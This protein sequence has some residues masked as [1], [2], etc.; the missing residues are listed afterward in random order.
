[1]KINLRYIFTV[2]ISLVDDI[3]I[4]VLAV[5]IMSLFGIKT[6]WWIIGVAARV[7]VAWSFIGYWALAK[8]PSLGF[9][10]M[11]GKTGLAIESIKRNGTVRIG[12]EL[13]QATAM[14]NIEQGA[15]IRVVS[16]SGLKLTV[17]EQKISSVGHSGRT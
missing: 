6:P 7:L 10:N 4:I 3:I 11:V 1:M 9:E 2:L 13:W 15:E 14:E 16:Q 8:N 5:W 12:H 17:V